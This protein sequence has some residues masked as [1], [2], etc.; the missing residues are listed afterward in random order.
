MNMHSVNNLI[1]SK[2][3]LSGNEVSSILIENG[4]TYRN[5]ASSK[6]LSE[7]LF[8]TQRKAINIINDGL[9]DKSTLALFYLQ[10]NLAE[11]DI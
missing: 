11:S 2:P 9:K 7:M 10:F 3:F 6:A 4:Y 1:E 8:C 5:K